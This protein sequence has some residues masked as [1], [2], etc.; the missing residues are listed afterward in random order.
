[1]NVENIES[2]PGRRNYF[3]FSAHRFLLV[4]RSHPSSEEPNS[5]RRIHTKRLNSGKNQKII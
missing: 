2:V 3:M 4:F 1:M 5:T